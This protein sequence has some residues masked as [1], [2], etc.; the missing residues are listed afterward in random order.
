MP[1]ADEPAPAAR[2]PGTLTVQQPEA[3]KPAG[4]QE[5]KSGKKKEEEPAVTI[6]AVG[7]K[8]IVTS[9][10]PETLRQVNMLVRLLTESPE[11]VSDFHVIRLKNATAT[12]AAKVIDEVFNGPSQPVNQPQQFVPRRFGGGIPTQTA[13]APATPHEAR[14]RVVADPETNMLLVRASPLDLV[15]IRHLVDTAID[16]TTPPDAKGVMRTHVIGPLKYAV[17]TEVLGVIKDAYREDTDNNPV[18]GAVGGGRFRT[19]VPN[20]NI[21]PDGQPRPVTLT[22]AVDDQTNSIIVQCNDNMYEDIRKLVEQL[23]TV[24]KNSTRTVQ[25]VRTQ[26]VDPSVLQQTIDA[27]QGRPT[28]NRGNGTGSAT[29]GGG[30]SPFRMTN[31]MNGGGGMRLFGGGTPGGSGTRAPGR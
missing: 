21:G 23:E 9:N 31:G 20:Q 10:D 2:P 14:V 19:P 12:E 3:A 22:V 6:T 30:S 17:A 25:V 5:S 15:A 7:N 16:V 27:L 26:G 8:L 28:T 1:K 18:G 13:P 11:G 24:S 4:D 29:F